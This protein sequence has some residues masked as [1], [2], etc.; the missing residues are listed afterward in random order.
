MILLRRCHNANGDTN[1]FSES[2]AQVLVKSRCYKYLGIAFLE[3]YKAVCGS[4]LGSWHSPMK[5]S[6]VW[7]WS[8]RSVAEHSACFAIKRCLGLLAFFLKAGGFD[9]QRFL[10]KPVN[11]YGA[12]SSRVR[13]RA[14]DCW[15]YRLISGNLLWE[16]TPVILP[17]ISPTISGRNCVLLPGILLKKKHQVLKRS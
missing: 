2:A 5:R 14:N 11:L 16:A 13:R 4:S 7:I 17:E 8:S 3:V 9:E 1:T 12:S 6:L 10:D 15:A